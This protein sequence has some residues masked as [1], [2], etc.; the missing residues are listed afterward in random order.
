MIFFSSIYHSALVLF[1][2]N[3]KPVYF[4]LATLLLFFLIII[5][6]PHHDLGKSKF[7]NSK[8]NEGLVGILDAIVRKS[9]WAIKCSTIEEDDEK[10]FSNIWNWIYKN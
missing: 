7:L 5:Y 1:N 3:S 6:S 9:E 2:C 8:I 10:D 4:N